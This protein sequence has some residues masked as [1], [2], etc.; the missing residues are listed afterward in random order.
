MGLVLIYRNK[1][2][3]PF[4]AFY[5]FYPTLFKKIQSSRKARF[6]HCITP[7]ELNPPILVKF[8]FKKKKNVKSSGPAV[9]LMGDE[10][11]Q[12]F[13]KNLN[14]DTDKKKKHSAYQ[15]R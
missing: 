4:I 3:E 7:E 10:M 8:C 15:R 14:S 5:Q 2:A 9:E 12:S 11:I 13:I 6:R 1:I